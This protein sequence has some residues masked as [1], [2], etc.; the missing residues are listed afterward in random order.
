MKEQESFL[1][2]FTPVAKM[3]FTAVILLIGAVVVLLAAL[4][5]APQMAPDRSCKVKD[6]YRITV[7]GHMNQLIFGDNAIL[8]SGDFSRPDVMMVV[9]PEPEDNGEFQPVDSNPAEIKSMLLAALSSADLAPEDLKITEVNDFE[10][11]MLPGVEFDFSFKGYDGVGYIFFARDLSI[12]G[13]ILWDKTRHSYAPRKLYRLN[14]LTLLGNYRNA[15]LNRPVIDSSKISYSADAIISALAEIEAGK[16]FYQQRSLAPENLLRAITSFQKAFRLLAE[17]DEVN[18]ITPETK[19]IFSDCV[20]ERTRMFEELR[21]EIFKQYN[22]N[23]M[24]KVFA[25]LREMRDEATLE[26]E[27]EW[28]EWAKDQIQE[29]EAAA[30]KKKNKRK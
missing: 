7:P 8:F 11:S 5:R 9:N 19:K 20:A 24:E 12:T 3:Q 27:L 14:N 25:L 30:L 22:L 29:Q 17:A 6:I 15:M 26:S 16:R 18:L 10:F 13:A 2:R 28:R 21:S 23:N 4:E 1:A